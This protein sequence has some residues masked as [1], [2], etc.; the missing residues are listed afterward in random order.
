[1]QSFIE[2]NLIRN[3]KRNCFTSFVDFDN[4]K[5]FQTDLQDEFRYLD[6]G[7]N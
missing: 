2:C 1:M 7:T 4:G 6:S 3:F 5:Y